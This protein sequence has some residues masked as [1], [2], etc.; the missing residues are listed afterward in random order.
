MSQVVTTYQRIVGKEF[1]IKNRE[2]IVNKNKWISSHYFNNFLYIL[3][4]S[5]NLKKQIEEERYALGKALLEVGN[6]IATHKDSEKFSINISTK[7]ILRK[8]IRFIQF[9]K[10]NNVD[11]AT[12]I[13]LLKVLKLLFDKA[14]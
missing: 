5:E 3:E 13:N 7:D 9:S 11:E 8:I 10:D 1:T 2:D 14:E 4:N 12:I 6:L